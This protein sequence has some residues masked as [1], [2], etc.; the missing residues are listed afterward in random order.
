MQTIDLYLFTQFGKVKDLFNGQ[1]D[2]KGLVEFITNVL[3]NTNSRMLPDV[4]DI[5]VL[6]SNHDFPFTEQQLLLFDATRKNYVLGYIWLS[7]FTIEHADHIPYHFINFI[8]TRIPGLN[9][10]KYMIN[11][12]ETQCLQNCQ[13]SCS[14]LRYLFPF[15]VKFSAVN[16]WKKYFIEVYHVK[17]KTDLKLM[18]LEFNLNLNLL[19]WDDLFHIFDNN[20]V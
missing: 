19:W 13:G 11:T 20:P 1:N 6:V 3:I 16:Y 10:A 4:S 12:Y 5:W 7:D 8:D 2:K 17:N 9:I 14:E 15:E 18:M